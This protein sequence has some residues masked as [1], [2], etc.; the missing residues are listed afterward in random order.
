M[1]YAYR[2]WLDRSNIGDK[3]PRGGFFTRRQTEMNIL[4][5]ELRHAHELTLGHLND[6]LGHYLDIT[7]AD[8]ARK[9]HT[10]P[11]DEL[12]EDKV[13][14]AYLIKHTGAGQPVYDAEDCA[15]FMEAVWKHNYRTAL[16]FASLHSPR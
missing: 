15:R 14:Y 6:A 5:H 10:T 16:A 3:L 13:T 8:P 11:P 7:G 4:N 1:N 2:F 9:F 12:A